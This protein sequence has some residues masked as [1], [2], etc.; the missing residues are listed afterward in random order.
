MGQ[1]FIRWPDLK[2]V[3]NV[4][5]GHVTRINGN[6]IK[7][8]KTSRDRDDRVFVDR[9]SGGSGLLNSKECTE[10]LDIL[11]LSLSGSIA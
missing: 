11:V 10:T 9:S 5:G 8:V 7:A 3:S 1:N 4:S 6:T 2:E